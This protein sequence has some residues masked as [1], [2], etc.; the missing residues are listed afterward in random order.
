MTPMSL[1]KVSITSPGPAGVDTGH[2]QNHFWAAVRGLPRKQTPLAETN[3]SGSS[4][5]R[6]MQAV[7]REWTS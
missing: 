4:A 2:G 1:N 6:L 5:D 7:A 3:P